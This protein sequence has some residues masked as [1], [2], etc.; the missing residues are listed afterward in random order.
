MKKETCIILILV[1]FIVGFGAGLITHTAMQPSLETRL[2]EEARRLTSTPGAGGQSP[3][4]YAAAQEAKRKAANEARLNEAIKSLKAMLEKDPDNVELLVGLG[5]NYFDIGQSF[6]AIEHYEKALKI[7]PDMPD[8][9]VDLGI[10]FRRTEKPDKAIES[11][12]RAIKVNPSHP[13]AYLNKAVVYMYDF[14][15]FENAHKNFKKFSEI[16]P[17]T[18]Q[19]LEQVKQNIIYLKEELDKGNKGPGPQAKE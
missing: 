19:M 16:A 11:F 1:A 15:D 6:A 10:M 17:K 4:E 12:D 18:H 9:I 13:N 14:G 3:E 2:Q 5:N 8:V 7:N